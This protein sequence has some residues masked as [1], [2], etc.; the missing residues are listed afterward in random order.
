MEDSNNYYLG[1]DIGTDSIGYAVANKKYELLKFKGEPM[2][3]ATLFES[4]KNASER[5]PFRT[6]RRRLDRRQARVSLLNELFANEICK[7][8]PKFFIR[9][10]ESALYAEDT[11]YGVKIFAG[12]GINDI[13]YYKQYPTIHHLIVDLMKSRDPRDVRLVYLACA[14]LVAHRGHFLIDIEPENARD[15]L[16]FKRAFDDLNQCLENNGYALPWVDELKDEKLLDI[17]QKRSRLTEK[18]VK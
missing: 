10:R 5:R 18:R 12:Q 11:R 9:R 13:E 1:L 14:W 16:N 17:L 8:D 3:G 2:W 4:A 15:V 6:S 7:I